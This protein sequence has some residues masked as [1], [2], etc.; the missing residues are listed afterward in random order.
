[1][2][3]ALKSVFNAFAGL[4]LSFLVWEA[5]V[6]IFSVPVYI[7][8]PPSNVLLESQRVAAILWHHSVETAI[9]TAISLAMG[10]VVGV[11]IGFLLG[12]SRA[13]SSLTYPLLGAF[14]ALPKSAFVPI[15]AVWFGIGFLPRVLSGFLIAFFPVVV[16]VVTGLTTIEPELW[17]MLKALGASRAQVIYKVGIP[18]TIPYFFASL[19]LAA[20]G[21]FIGNVVGEMLAA[22]EG[23]GYV[24]LLATNQFNMG[25]AFGALTI[26]LIMGL[27][28]FLVFDELEK[29]IA[30]WAYRGP[31]F[32]VV[33]P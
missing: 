8:P 26:L 14:N 31:D 25:L 3:R 16:N 9:G 7:L 33:T 17:D 24:L 2:S 1:M 28:I 13:M 12:Y 22:G 30:P 19:K 5:V 11:I 10:A 29:V 20:A 32:T 6:R 21:A 27:V 18:R 23:L 15:L 4:L